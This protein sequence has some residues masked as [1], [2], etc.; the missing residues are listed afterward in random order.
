VTQ[1]A[2]GVPIVAIKYARTMMSRRD[3]LDWLDRLTPW[4]WEFD[5]LHPDPWKVAAAAGVML[6]FFALFTLLGTRHFLKRD[7]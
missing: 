4:G 6:G 7:L 2:I 5:L 3:S 1:M